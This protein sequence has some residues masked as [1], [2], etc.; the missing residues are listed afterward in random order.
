[1]GIFSE[2]KIRTLMIML[3]ERKYYVITTFI[4]L[5]HALFGVIFFLTGVIPMAVFNVFSP[6]IYLS[7]RG[8][9]KRGKLVVFLFFAYMEIIVH[10][11]LTAYFVGGNSGFGQYIIAVVP[12]GFLG[13][14]EVVKGRKRFTVPLILGIVASTIYILCRQYSYHTA[15]VYVLPE[16]LEESLF[17]FN[18]TGTF[19][20]LLCAL[21][22]YT[23]TL[24]DMEQQLLKQNA[25]LNKRA[26]TDPL[27]NLLNRRS[28]AKELAVAAGGE[29]PFA[30]AMCD[31]DDF[32]K[33]NDSYGHEA[34]D[35]VLREVSRIITEAVPEDCP[36]CRW[37][38]EEFVILFNDHSLREA[39]VVAEQIRERIAINEIPFYAHTL[40]IT[41]TIGAASHRDGQSVEETISDA[42]SKLYIGKG[43][44]KNQVV[45]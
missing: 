44:G 3:S 14:Y 43:N 31:I 37:G 11:V 20:F 26:S 21:L 42:D 32:K 5:V 13:A 29:A 30:V 7:M 40:K 17:I 1:M 39:L 33:V 28:M 38:G 41:I 27:T 25:I 34:G 2:K 23:I 19:V 9:L 24:N 12:L 35:L 18:S 4:G 10:A 45:S 8:I 6:I 15:P 36:I 22:L 16:S